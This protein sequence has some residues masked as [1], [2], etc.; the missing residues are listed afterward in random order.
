MLNVEWCVG[1]GA[2]QIESI[3]WLREFSDRY[4]AAWN[5]H[6]PEAVA[7]C[8]TEDVF[9]DDPGLARPAQGRKELADFVAMGARAFPDY[10]FTLRGAPAIS[11][12]GRVAYVPVRMTGT[13]TGPIDPPGFRPTGRSFSFDAIDVWTFREGLLWRYRAAYDFSTLARQLRLLPKREGLSERGWTRIQ[14]LFGVRFPG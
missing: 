8:A 4:L 2:E 3:E 1:D 14:R 6:D 11:D 13:N 12:D 7:A 5:S 10:E 9:W